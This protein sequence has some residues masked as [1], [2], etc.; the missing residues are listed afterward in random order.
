VYRICMHRPQGSGDSME[1]FGE[2][3]RKL[4]HFWYLFLVWRRVAIVRPSCSNIVQF[5]L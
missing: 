5:M 4:G 1:I 3:G 2:R